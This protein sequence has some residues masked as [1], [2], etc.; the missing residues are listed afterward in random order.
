MF[1]FDRFLCS[2][3]SAAIRAWSRTRVATL[4]ILFSIIIVGLAHIYIPI[5]YQLRQTRLKCPQSQ[6]APA[7]FQGIWTLI[8]CSLGPS[9]TM[10]V[11]GLL[12]IRHIQQ[13]VARIKTQIIQIQPQTEPL[14]QQK[15]L[16]RPRTTDRQ[17]IQMTIVQCIYFSLMSSPL[18]INWIYTSMRSNVVSDALQSAEDDFFFGHIYYPIFHRRMYKFLSIYTVKSIVSR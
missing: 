11:F 15:Q 13:S 8:I 4:I 1:V 5:Q 16:Q 14:P 12:T 7:A 6:T 17:L 18:S 9:I 2:S 10:L 3:R